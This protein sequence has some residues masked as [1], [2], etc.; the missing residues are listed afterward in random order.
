M[1]S[2][3]QLYRIKQRRKIKHL[4]LKL[5]YDYRCDLINEMKIS[6]YCIL[7]KRSFREDELQRRQ[8]DFFGPYDA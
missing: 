8:L 6:R 3:I 7:R 1:R 5:M 4:K 2:N